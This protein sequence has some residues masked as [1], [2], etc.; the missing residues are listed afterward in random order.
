M[1]F[2]EKY[3]MCTYFSQKMFTNALNI[4][5]PLQDRVKKSAYGMETHSP[6]KK[7]FKAQQSFK[8]V[9]LLGHERTN[10]Y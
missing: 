5:L 10:H 7:K 1:T 6:V 9:G 4:S 2:T 8:K 3:V